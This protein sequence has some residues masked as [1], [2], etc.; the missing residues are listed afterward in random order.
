MK[1]CR[2]IGYCYR[3]KQNGAVYDPK[4]L[5]PCLTCGFHG[6]GVEPKIIVYEKD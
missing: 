1:K 6:G 4:G 2:I 3:S 5:A